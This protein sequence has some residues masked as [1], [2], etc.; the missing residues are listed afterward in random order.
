MIAFSITLTSSKKEDEKNKK[1]KYSNNKQYEDLLN[2]L[3]LK[4]N[5]PVLLNQ[6]GN[7]FPYRSSYTGGVLG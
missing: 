4:P 6:L 7:I 5:S 2:I 3:I 1:G